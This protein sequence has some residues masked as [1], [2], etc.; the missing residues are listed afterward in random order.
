MN[1]PTAVASDRFDTPLVMKGG[2][3]SP[4]RWYPLRPLRG[5]PPCCCATTEFLRYIFPDCR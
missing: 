3:L 4:P 5:L 1:E 2:A